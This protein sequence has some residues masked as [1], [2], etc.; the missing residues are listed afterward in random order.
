MNLLGCIGEIMNNSGL[1]NILEVIY[2]GNAVQH[3]L[4]GKAF[5]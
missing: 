5:S 3:M 4:Q 2:G 1:K